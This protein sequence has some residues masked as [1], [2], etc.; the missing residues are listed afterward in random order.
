LNC[1]FWCLRLQPF[2]P[3]FNNHRLNLLEL[4][5]I[6]RSLCQYWSSW[7]FRISGSIKFQMLLG[8]QFNKL[9]KTRFLHLPI[10]N[11]YYISSECQPSVQRWMRFGQILLFLV[12]WSKSQCHPFDFSAKNSPCC[13]KNLLLSI[14]RNTSR[15][16]TA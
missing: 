16:G 3:S 8:T 5:R 7:E 6:S 10:L 9:F 14:S 12:D 11:W 13:T 4:R 15:F 2:E 1:W